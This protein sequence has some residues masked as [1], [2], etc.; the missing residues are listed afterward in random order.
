MKKSKSLLSAQKGS[1]GVDASTT[2]LSIQDRQQADKAIVKL[3]NIGGRLPEE[4]VDEAKS[5]TGTSVTPRKPLRSAHHHQCKARA[6]QLPP[7]SLTQ[8][9]ARHELLHPLVLMS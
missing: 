4:P 9:L 7:Q 1:A 3:L 2:T 6:L 8:T 5:T